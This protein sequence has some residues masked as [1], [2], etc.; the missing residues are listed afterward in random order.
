MRLCTSGDMQASCS[1][2]AACARHPHRYSPQKQQLHPRRPRAVSAAATAAEQSGSSQAVNAAAAGAAAAP[3]VPTYTCR[4][5]KGEF[6]EAGNS[7]TACRFHPCIYTGGEVA[8][9]RRRRRAI[10][11]GWDRTHAQRSLGCGRV[12]WWNIAHLVTLEACACC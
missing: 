1:Y 12:G 7:R 5:C 6:T 4:R 10:G 8:K 9:V 2:P 11:M 3:R